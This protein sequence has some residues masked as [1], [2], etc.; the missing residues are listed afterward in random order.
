MIDGAKITLETLR[1]FKEML[2]NQQE[3][4]HARPTSSE[5]NVASD[6]QKATPDATR[7][8]GRCLPEDPPLNGQDE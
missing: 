3:L 7:R 2:K 5:E 1:R 4:R 6:E 8:A